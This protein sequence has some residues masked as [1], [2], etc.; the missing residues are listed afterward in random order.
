MDQTSI[1]ST[2]EQEAYAQIEP[3]LLS[4]LE[5][6]WADTSLL[7]LDVRKNY[8]SIVYGSSVVARLSAG[9]SPT[10]SVLR[11]KNPIPGAVED[12]NFCKLTLSDLA[13]AERYIPQMQ[14]ALQSIL[15]RVPKEFSCCSRYQACSDA[16][17]CV[18]PDKS[19]ALRCA[20]RKVLHG[21][22]VYYGP[23]RNV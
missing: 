2:S 14:E 15:D 4:V 13:E 18:N 16:R 17:S 7:R 10:L 19:L 3:K 11:C 21:G 22:K 12:G 6:N 23:N 8:C 20:Y 1:F 9:A 5:E